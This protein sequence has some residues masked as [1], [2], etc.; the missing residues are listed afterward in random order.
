MNASKN[1]AIAAL[2]GFLALH[3][4]GTAV[5]YSGTQ[6]ATPETALSGNTALC[7]GTY[8]A[9]AFGAQS[10]V[11]GNQ[12][13]TASFTAASYTPAANG[14][15]SFV[16]AFE[17]DG[18]TVIADYSI[19]TSGTDFIIGSTTINTGVQVSFAQTLKIPAV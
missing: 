7:T 8:S 4:N 6:P 18:T 15:A 12:Q 17:S 1:G 14:T 11:S 2:A 19:G 3:N 13:A 5:I 9:T 16:R 10:F